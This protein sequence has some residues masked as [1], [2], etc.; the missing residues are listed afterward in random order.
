MQAHGISDVRSFAFPFGAANLTSKKNLSVSDMAL[1]GVKPGINRGT[2]DLNMLKACGLQENNDGIG[3]AMADLEALQEND[4]WLIL[5]THDVRTAPSPWGATP[6]DYQKLLKAV[7][8]SGAEVLTV[9]EM[10]NRL[11]A[12]TA[13]AQSVAA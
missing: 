5:F 6:E 7:Q 1:R 11:D 10:V 13:P 12:N 3:R 9:G 2:V 8:A 4:G